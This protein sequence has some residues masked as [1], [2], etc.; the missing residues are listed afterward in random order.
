MSW[1]MDGWPMM[2]IGIC[3]VHGRSVQSDEA[4]AMDDAVDDAVG[5]DCSAMTNRNDELKARWVWNTKG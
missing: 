4:W 1:R 2:M 3:V 5:Q